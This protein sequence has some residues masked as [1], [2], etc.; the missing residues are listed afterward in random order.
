M[1]I[2]QVNI[3]KTLIPFSGDV[4]H[5]MKKGA[6]SKNF[7][8]EVVGQEGK[9]KGYG[10]GAPREYVTG[11][12]HKDVLKN[13]VKL[14]REGLFPWDLDDVNQI[15]NFIDDIPYTK[16]F[17]SAICALEIS[18]LDAL[19]KLQ[20]KN[21]LEYF[22]KDYYVDSINYGG[23][24]P[25]NG[26]NRRIEVYRLLKKLGIDQLRIKLGKNVDENIITI[27]EVKE[28]FG[29]DCDLRVDVNGAWDSQLANRHVDTLID[30]GI[31]IIEQPF[32]P[33]GNGIK[34]FHEKICSSGIL[35]MA[36]ES[37]CNMNDLRNIINDGCY[38]VVNIRLSKCGGLRRSLNMMDYLRK[39]GLSFQVGCQLGETG[40]LSAAGRALSLLSGDALYH[41][42]SY[43]KYLLKENLTSRDISFGKGGYAEPL[44][45]PGL[46]VGVDTDKLNHMSNNYPIY[47]VSKS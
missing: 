46:G 4:S 8:V 7:V 27:K 13:T 1:Q 25:L 2:Q 31:K 12:Y 33:G 5:S 43:D 29:D 10:E 44:N 36:D 28:Y 30:Q 35:L 21:I 47:S 37:V 16:Q 24:I 9:I 45:G 6:F 19:G 22:N 14:I 34:D 18:L 39:E 17:N 26:K 40:I 23:V 32:M 11:E 20:N 41:D 38:G 3:Y 42:G 15:W